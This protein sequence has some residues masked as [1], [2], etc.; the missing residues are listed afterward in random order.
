MICQLRQLVQLSRPFWEGEGGGG[1]GDGETGGLELG[2]RM[3]PSG[4]IG[5]AEILEQCRFVAAY[6]NRRE[7]KN[8]RFF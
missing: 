5:E 3:L 7:P 4:E 8:Q 2:G 1:G 6:V